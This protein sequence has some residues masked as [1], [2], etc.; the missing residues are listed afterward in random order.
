MKISL[1]LFL[2]LYYITCIAQRT[3]T[4]TVTDN[5]GIPVLGATVLIKGTDNEVNTDFDGNYSIE[6]EEDDVLIFSS[7]GYETQEISA[8][9]NNVINVSLVSGI[10]GCYFWN[11]PTHSIKS[12][13]GVNYKTLGIE[14]KTRWHQLNHLELNGRITTNLE[15]NKE[16]QVETI[17][18]VRI[19]GIYIKPG[20]SFHQADFKSNRLHKYEFFIT[21]DFGLGADPHQHIKISTGLINYS[22]SQR[23]YYEEVGYGIEIRKRVFRG[24][25]FH[26]WLYVLGRN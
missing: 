8:G 13:Y 16:I 21:K 18:P 6:V 26:N 11:D 17:K 22:S 5:S 2:S 19:N 10:T 3:I 4:G 14:F 23:L 24:L 25:L 20:L 1:V 9:K 7:V 12:M 15:S